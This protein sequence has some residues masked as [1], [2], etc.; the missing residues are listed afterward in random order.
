MRVQ[1]SEKETRE[2]AQRMREAL[3]S[4]MPRKRATAFSMES[5]PKSRRRTLTNVNAIM[6]TLGPHLNGNGGNG[7]DHGD[8]FEIVPP[9]APTLGDVAAAPIAATY[10][11]T[12]VVTITVE[13]GAAPVHTIARSVVSNMLPVTLSREQVLDVMELVSR[14]GE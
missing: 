9:P 6:K 11:P 12:P 8:D 4:G 7:H 14:W 10:N 2:V 3:R 1:W 5:L 13:P